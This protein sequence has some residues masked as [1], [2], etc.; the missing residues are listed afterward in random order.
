MDSNK[1]ILNSLQFS[2]V[3]DLLTCYFVTKRV[4]G[5]V[6][7][8]P[9]HLP[10]E[11]QS[12]A[13]MSDVYTTYDQPTDDAVSVTQ[14]TRP[15]KEDKESKCWSLAFLKR[16]YNY[17]L[18][19]Y[20]LQ[21]GLT[22]NTNFL[23]E[24]EVWI[25]DQ[26]TYKNCAGY[27]VIKL[28][29]QFA[30]LTNIP[31]LVI[32]YGGIASA[33]NTALP[34]LVDL[35]VAHER[36]HKVIYDRKISLYQ[37]LPDEARRDLQSVYP[38][39][40]KALKSYLKMPYP[41]P[42]KSNA[43]PKHWKA[44]NNF[45]EKY[46]LDDDFASVVKLQ[47]LNF[48]EV[49]VSR[50]KHEYDVKPDSVFG[51][52]RLHSDPYIGMKTYGPA[53]LAPHRHIQIFCVLHE[54]YKEVASKVMGYLKGNDSFKGIAQ[55]AKI[56][57]AVQSGFSI[58]YANKDNPLPEIKEKLAERT[59]DPS[60]QYVAIFLSAH[61]KYE[62]DH[63]KRIIYYQLKEEFLHRGI[64]TQVLDAEKVRLSKNFHYSMPN[65]ATAM[66][67]KL[68]G[69]PWCLP[70]SSKDDLVIGIGA[71][72]NME[73]GAKYLGSAFS[74]SNEGRFHGFD[75]FRSSQIAEL[76]G[77]ILMAVRSYRKEQPTIKRLIIHFYKA[78][79]WKEVAPIEQ[80]LKSLGLDIPLYVV[81]V[82]K[83]LSQDVIGFDA[84]SPQLMPVSGTYL[85]LGQQQYLFYN[86]A[87][88]E[89]DVN[90][91]KS[92]PFPLKLSISSYPHEELSKET[93]EGLLQQIGM[94]SKLYWKSVS[95][96]HMPVTLLYPEMVARMFPY[97]QGG[98]L[99]EMGKRTL[100]FL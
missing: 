36:I 37:Y 22:V 53:V 3:S 17:R 2:P 7:V 94:F 87:R 15:R 80:G 29:V 38:C 27:S 44:I 63:S 6:P 78:I 13:E 5:A 20:F 70:S 74:F 59:F 18:Q 46:L 93:V 90:V 56:N 28:R 8:R 41:A 98:E 24:T 99:P 30:K 91:P 81:S 60:T 43:Y 14:L 68:G 21:K 47:S 51:G 19:S 9:K 16:Y 4:D 89:Q 31:E 55:F 100:W 42:D 75:C 45:R 71:F 67:A 64:V 23:S 35:E 50:L 84:S 92:Y 73:Q 97:F 48:V 65:I 69:M 62:Q 1:L 77:S 52:N 57:Y 79:S 66:L 54:S 85:D 11:L 39:L 40:N 32:S 96:Q 72:R 26:S 58:S 82:N 49:N 25:P 10:R 88:T 12:L 86:N 76:A 95:V 61:S 33:L 34:D 83:T